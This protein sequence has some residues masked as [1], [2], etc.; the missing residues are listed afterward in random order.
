MSFDFSGLPSATFPTPTTPVAK[1]LQCKAVKLTSADF[2]T[3]GTASVKAYIPADASITNIRGWMKT[4]FTGNGVTAATLSIGVTG[5]ATKYLSALN[6]FGTAGQ[7]FY[8]GTLTNIFQAYDPAAPTG[9]IPLLFTGT[10][11]TGNPTAGEIYLLI[12]YVR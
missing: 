4:A 10:A 2:T 6:V 9:D 11:T 5:T 8:P 12:E 3:G 7:T 1:D